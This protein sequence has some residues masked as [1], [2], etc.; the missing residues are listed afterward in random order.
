MMKNFLL[1][2]I[3]LCGC[4][5]LT[6]AQDVAPITTYTPTVGNRLTLFMAEISPDEGD[7]H[8]YATIAS[9]GSDRITADVEIYIKKK[10]IRNIKIKWEPIKNFVKK[11]RLEGIQTLRYANYKVSG[12][13]I[14]CLVLEVG[15]TH[16]WIAMKGK[17]TSFPGIVL[18]KKQ[19]KILIKLLKIDGIPRDF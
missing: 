16:L 8:Q 5:S 4:T 17:N 1:S 19:D 13:E 14:P 18:F 2:C 15:S 9:I 7:I 12:V 3:I 11:H 10:K 6:T